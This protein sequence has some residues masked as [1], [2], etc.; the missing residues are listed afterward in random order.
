MLFISCI[1]FIRLYL[2]RLQ[3]VSFA[4]KKSHTGYRDL[5][6]I[7]LLFCYFF[8]VFTRLKMKIIFFS[9]LYFPAKKKDF[10]FVILLKKR[11]SQTNKW[12]KRKCFDI[13]FSSHLLLLHSTL[14]LGKFAFIWKN[15]ACEKKFPL[16]PLLP[17]IFIYISV[18]AWEQLASTRN[19]NICSFTFQFH[20]LSLCTSHC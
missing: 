16:L 5:C 15:Y 4:K 11:T 9:P 6:T 20:Y 18:L 10:L 17:L 7:S 13:L 8:F 3:I 14:A 2:Y 19:A 12:T 1:F